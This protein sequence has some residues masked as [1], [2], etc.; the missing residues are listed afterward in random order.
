MNWKG[1]VESGYGLIKVLSRDLPGG[2]EE[3][4]EKPSRRSA[5]VSKGAP[6]EYKSVRHTCPL[7]RH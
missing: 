7:L 3:S 1:F 4:L 2:N 5:R 6:S